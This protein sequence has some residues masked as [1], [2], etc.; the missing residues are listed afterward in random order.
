MPFLAPSF[1]RLPPLSLLLADQVEPRKKIARHLG[2]E[3]AHP[4]ALPGQRQRGLPGPLFRVRAPARRDPGARKAQGQPAANS[5]V[6][7]AIQAAPKVQ[8]YG[9]NRTFNS[10]SWQ[11]G[12]SMYGPSDWWLIFGIDVISVGDAVDE[13]LGGE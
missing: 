6:F 9:C 8:M 11:T 4:A 3:A 7:N 2:N 10:S 1:A 12:A 13:P 5:A